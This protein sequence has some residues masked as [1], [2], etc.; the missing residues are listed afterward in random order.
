[1]AI[2]KGTPVASLFAT[3]LGTCNAN[4]VVRKNQVVWEPGSQAAATK[5]G[6]LTCVQALFQKDV[7]DLVLLSE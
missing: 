7:G 2:P 1:M 3:V 5:A 6:C 4:P